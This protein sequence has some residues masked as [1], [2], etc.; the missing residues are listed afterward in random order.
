MLDQ[1]RKH[2]AAS[3]HPALLQFLPPSTVLALGDFKSCPT[4]TLPIPGAISYLR[5]LQTIFPGQ[6]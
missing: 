1:L 6:Q 5:H 3:V 2:S 4:E